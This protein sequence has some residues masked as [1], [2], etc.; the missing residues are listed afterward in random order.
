MIPYLSGLIH[1]AIWCIPPAFRDGLKR[2]ITTNYLFFD[3]CVYFQALTSIGVA[4]AITTARLLNVV[5][6]KDQINLSIHR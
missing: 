6:E 2:N 3:V 4:K 1:P 5:D